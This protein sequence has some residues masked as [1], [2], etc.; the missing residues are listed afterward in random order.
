[1]KAGDTEFFDVAQG[2][3]GIV[4]YELDL[5]KV[6]HD[7]VTGKAA[8]ARAARRVSKGGKTVVAE[9][10]AEGDQSMGR[11]IYSYKRGVLVRRHARRAIASA[12]ATSTGLA[13]PR[14]P[15]AS[16]APPGAADA[17]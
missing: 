16:P 11:Y 2:N 7:K 13:M 1:M 5:L 3:A 17:Q 4:Q 10:K 6:F 8:S 9:L 14:T 12:S 15:P